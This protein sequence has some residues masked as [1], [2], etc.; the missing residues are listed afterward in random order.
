[1]RW[2][3]KT[4]LGVIGGYTTYASYLYYL[5]RR[6]IRTRDEGEVSEQFQSLKIHGRFENPFREYRP[7]TIYEFL[8][9]RLIEFSRFEERRGGVPF[10]WEDIRQAVGWTPVTSERLKLADNADIGYTW[11][12]QSCGILHSNGVRFLMDPMLSDF[13]VD[14]KFGPRRIVPSPVKV[15]EAG[16]ILKPEYVLISHDHPDHLDY[17]SCASVKSGGSV[18]KWIVPLGL[19]V[20]L[21]KKCGVPSDKIIELDWWK[22]VLLEDD[23]EIVCLP[24]MHWSGQHIIDTNASLWCTFMIRKR[25]KSLFFHGG[26]TGYVNG[27]FKMIGEKY[28]PV[29][30]AAVPIGQYCPAWHQRPR[31]VSPSE[32]LK[33]S[34]EIGAEKIVGVHWGTFVLSSEEWLEPRNELLR[35]SKE[36]NLGKAVV[37]PTHGG[38]SI[39]DDR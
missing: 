11:L 23:F 35:A 27:L 18:K 16:E 38:I 25:G 26:D 5:T 34:I 9:M 17:T 32:S 24:A 39:Y 7:Q 12:G 4:V 22:S 19:G 2:P 20:K 14:S 21:V 1:M 6:E 15:E 33:M 8:L 36:M 29:K 30:I 37:I 13:M 28:G 3:T 10:E 31:H